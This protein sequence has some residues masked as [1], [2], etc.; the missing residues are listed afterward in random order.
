[1]IWLL[2]IALAVLIAVALL[3]RVAE[4][5][6]KPMDGAARN[7]APGEFVQLTDGVTHIHRRG[8]LRGPW[9][10]CIHGLTTPEFVWDGM[11]DGLTKL[12]F[13]VLSYDLYGRGFSD[14]PDLPNSREFFLRQLEEVMEV[15]GVSETATLIGYS[16]GGSIASAYAV[17]Y[18]EK[19]DRL[20][21]LAPAGLRMTDN[22]F[23]RLVRDTPVLGDWLMTVLGGRLCKSGA[24][25]EKDT[26]STVPNIAHRQ[27]AEVDYRG[28]L[29]SVLSSQR[30]MLA[31]D[32]FDDHR[33][34]EEERVP[35]LAIWGKKDKVI[36]PSALGDMSQANRGA[37]HMTIEDA[38]HGLPYTHPRTVIEALK[39]FLREGQ[40]A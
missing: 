22:R 15:A 27:A 28:F 16:M 38:G 11:I 21:L 40:K 31:E 17:K 20:I 18:P 29:R 19:V 4:A 6:R 3:P 1:M 13:R 23:A 35:V 32:M 8:T 14:R 33:K 9:V 5:R 2:L 26:L 24:L 10:V 12:G 7:T 39:E 25:A 37:R 36:P 30:H 34:L